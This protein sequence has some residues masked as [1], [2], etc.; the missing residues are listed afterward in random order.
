MDPFISLS[1]VVIVALVIGGVWGSVIISSLMKQRT[2]K[3]ESGRADPRLEQV[4]EALEQLEGRL[5]LLEEEV[6]FFRELH[7]ADTP[8]QLPLPDSPAE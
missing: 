3:L 5:G 7:G 2:L 8:G 6:Q 1:L 4:L